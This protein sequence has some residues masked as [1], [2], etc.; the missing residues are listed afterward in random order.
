MQTLPLIPAA[1]CAFSLFVLFSLSDGFFGLIFG[2]F[3][4]FKMLTKLTGL[5]LG[6]FTVLLESG[7]SN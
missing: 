5:S 7:S 3:P 6:N 4:F 2:G 1:Y